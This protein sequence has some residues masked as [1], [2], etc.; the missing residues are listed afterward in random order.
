V[1]SDFKYPKKSDITTVEKTGVSLQIIHELCHKLNELPADKQFFSKVHKILGDRK[2]LIDENKVDWAMGELLAYA[3]LVKE[4]H[5]VRLS[6]QDA[7]R[8][9]FAHRHVSFTVEDMNERYMPLSNISDNPISFTAYNSPLSEYGVMGFEYGY[10]L[11]MPN[12]LTIWEAQFGD[13]VNV[14][15]VIIDQ[16]ISSAEEKWGVMNGL[17]L[18]LPHGFEGQGPEHS[19][20]RLERFLAL[21]AANNMQI[22]NCTT[23]ANL[24]HALR[25]QIHRNF[26][27]PMIVFTPKS[28][29]R[30]P[31]CISS[32]DDLQNGAFSEVI[33]DK[34]VNENNV[35]RVVFCSGKI[36]YD[37]LARKEELNA[38]N[39]ALVRIE[40][41]H[42]FPRIQIEE[43][44]KKYQKAVLLLWVQEEPENMG[45][46]NYIRS[47]MPTIQLVPVARRASG[48]PATGLSGLHTVGQNEIINKVFKKCQCEKKLPYCNLVCMEGKSREEILKQHYYFDSESRFS[49]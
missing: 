23:P 37:L 3:T 22:M 49:I 6:G 30:H 44:I 28:L 34:D 19:S 25:R 5:P 15:Q 38:K 2:K 14:A 27:L 47:M 16:Y 12:G 9:T 17:V 10:S 32:L 20:A 7:E 18:F 41:L 43:V 35:T 11:G 31:K 4:G 40:Q 42:P 46:W 48:S 39:V 26:R 1:W 24:F 45:A 8:G 21:S 29:L 36:Y 33:D 13:F